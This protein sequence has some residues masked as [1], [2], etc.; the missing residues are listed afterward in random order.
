[1]SIDI[2]T[3][4]KTKKHNVHFLNRYY[5]FI[6]LCKEKNANIESNYVE[7]HHILPKSKDMFPEFKDFKK[8]PDNCIILTYRQHVI[9]H[10][11]LMRAYNTRSQILSFLRTTQQ[12]QAKDLKIKNINT[13]MIEKAKIELSNKMK[14]KF[15][16]GYDQDNK[17]ITKQE[18]REKLSKMK[19]EFYRDPENRKK[20]SIACAG[21]KRKNTENIRL[22]ALRRE[23]SPGDIYV[24]NAKKTIENKKKLGTWKRVPK[25]GL[26]ATP[27]GIFSWINNAYR[28]WCL[29]PDKPLSIH[30]AKKSILCN[31]NVIGLTPRELGFYFIEKDD[32]QF[33]E[34]Y[35][36]ANQVHLP[37]PSHPLLS[38]LSDFLLREN[39]LPQN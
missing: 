10:Y 2:L 6:L 25:K 36:L 8:Y 32:P 7:K 1:M 3:I 11:I 30:V 37:E 39:L 24:I 34:W 18:T 5:R 12:K 13:K 22:A 21:K 16:R 29:N 38:E 23:R 17:P 14:G 9:A 19:T 26:Y 4:M 15:T 20:Q 31:R 33:S 35:A 27:V 28:D